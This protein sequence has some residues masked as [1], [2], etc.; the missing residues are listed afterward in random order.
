[1]LKKTQRFDD[2]I[3]ERVSKL[4][5]PALN[6]IFKFYT[7]LGNAG[8]IW[9]LITI[10]F[11]FIEMRRIVAINMVIGLSMTHVIGEIFIKH[12]VCRE[13]PCHRIDDS[14]QIIEKPKYYSFPSGHTAA[15]FCMVAVSMMRCEWYIWL[16]ILFLAVMMG[17]SRVYLMVHYFTDVFVGMIIGLI[18]G[19]LSV[20]LVNYGY[21]NLAVKIARN[22]D[23][24][25]LIQKGGAMPIT[26]T[27]MISEAIIWA[28]IA[29]VG[30]LLLY[31]FHRKNNR[32]DAQ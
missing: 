4:H 16:P 27:H 13:R 30:L 3:I 1:M 11:F 8:I 32:N 23:V 2:A 19:R 10:P 25:K 20:S 15:S 14:Q 22:P 9:F 29:V 17:F 21:Y 31:Y 7:N 18:S 28:V 24:L 26:H 5:K 6:K 12:I